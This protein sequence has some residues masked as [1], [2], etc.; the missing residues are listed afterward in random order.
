MFLVRTRE[1][2]SLVSA[3][4]QR[5]ALVD[6]EEEVR[7]SLARSARLLEDVELA[8][9]EDTS[10][11]VRW[12]LAGNE[13]LSAKTQDLLA[14][15][16]DAGVR[17]RL[18]GNGTVTKAVVA[19]LARDADPRVKMALVV[20]AEVALE[21]DLPVAVLDLVGEGHALVNSTL[22]A[23]GADEEVW[24]ALRPGWTGTL[25]ELLKA[26]AEFASEQ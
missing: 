24:R 10:L 26:S 11:R 14:R 20:N 8:L 12:M 15:D 21:E 17:A 22:D 4:E 13:S 5:A 19:V 23:A 1:G 16:L 2:A 6:P 18:A 9:A 25:G 7:S 3:E